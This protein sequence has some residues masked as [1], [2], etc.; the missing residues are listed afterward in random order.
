MKL[1][2]L[3]RIETGAGSQMRW[4]RG[5]SA[6]LSCFILF[7]PHLF[8]EPLTLAREENWLIMR[9][10]HLPAGGI[11]INYLEAYCR[12]GSTDA[13]WVTHTVI[14]HRSELISADPKMVRVRDTLAD[15]VTVEHT[16]EARNDEVDF[17]LVAHNPTDQR[18][19]AH[20]AQP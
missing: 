3:A 18:S 17:A 14:P 19:E 12:A 7:P 10:P 1:K 9:A 8:A 6:A 16:I 2:P 4:R 13:D 11:R 5:V 15:G 20:W